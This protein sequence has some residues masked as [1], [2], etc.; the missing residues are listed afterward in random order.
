V[1][2]FLARTGTV[3]SMVVHTMTQWQTLAARS[4]LV[5]FISILHWGCASGPQLQGLAKN[6]LG[7]NQYFDRLNA[8]VNFGNDSDYFHLIGYNFEDADGLLMSTTV[9][10]FGT[11]ATNFKKTRKFTILNPFAKPVSDFSYKLEGSPLFTVSKSTCG[12]IL[13]GHQ[14]CTVWVEFHPKRRT[15]DQ[16]V[17]GRHKANLI[18]T[19]SAGPSLSKTFF[20]SA[21]K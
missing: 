16:T 7:K 1:I 13:K 12:A 6:E 21:S 5:L 9:F 20:G 17:V 18:V 19:S 3:V 4:F 14:V 2:E 15:P 11:V 8:F 10:D